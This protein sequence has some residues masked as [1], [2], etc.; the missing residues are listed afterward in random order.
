MNRTEKILIC[1]NSSFV[2]TGLNEQIVKAGFKVDCFTRGKEERIENHVTGDVLNLVNNTNLEE[3]Y[4]VVFNFILIKN[5]NVDE[6]I[7]YID[8]LV[9]FCKK[10]EVTKLVHISSIIV[11]DRKEKYINEETKIGLNSKKTGYGD[12][13]IAVDQYLDSL[14]NLPFSISYIRPGYVIADDR[15]IPFLKKLPF[16]FTLIKGSRNS[17]LPIVKR[18]DIHRAI[19]NLLRQEIF[20]KVSLFVPS[21]NKSKLQYAREAGYHNFLFLPKFLILSTANMLRE[22]GIISNSLFERIEGLYTENQYDS[23]RTENILQ[24]K[25]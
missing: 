21:T 17:Y 20:E 24:V 23:R 1:G 18:D 9:E 6:N 25:F 11:Y 4:L 12:I 2:A 13:K 7:Q 22:V 15:Q 19:V 3:K 14:T 10:R 5:G 8:Q 16:G